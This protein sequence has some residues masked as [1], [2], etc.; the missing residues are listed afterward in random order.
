[1][2]R[3]PSIGGLPTHANGRVR[4]LGVRAGQYRLIEGAS[5]E[6][7][8]FFSVPGSG[9]EIFHVIQFVAETRVGDVPA[10]VGYL[11]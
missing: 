4:F 1:M 10:G 6:Q 2:D 9:L 8:K 11:R 3:V 7:S 5:G